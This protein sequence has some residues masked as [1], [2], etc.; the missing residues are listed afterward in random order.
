MA[1]VSSGGKCWFG[2]DSKT[3]E[4][5]VNKAKGKV[6]GT[7][8]ER[9]LNIYSWVRFSGK[10]LTFLLEGAET[11]CCLKVGER[12]KK[13]GQRGK[14]GDGHLDC[15]L[16]KGGEREIYYPMA[17][18]SSGGK[19]WFGVDSKTFEI[20]VNKAKGKV[21]GTVCERGLNIY[22]WVRFSGKGLTFLL[23]GAETYCCLKV[24]ERFKKA[25]AEGKEGRSVVG[26]WQLLARKLRS[27]GFSLSQKGEE[28]SN[29]S[30]RGRGLKGVSVG[31]ED[32]LVE[33]EFSGYA[34]LRNVV[35][36]EIE[37]G[38]IDSNKE[39]ELGG[40][41]GGLSDQPPNLNSLKSWAQSRVKWFKGKCLLLD[42]WNPSVGCLIEDRKSQEVWVRILGLPLHLWG[43]SFFK[44]LGETCDRFVGVDKD[45]VK[46]QNLYPIVVGDTPWI[47]EVQPSW[48][49]RGRG[50]KDEGEVRSRALPRVAE[51]CSGK[52]MAR[53]R[54]LTRCSLQKREKTLFLF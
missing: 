2:V 23:E 12:F 49:C 40:E 19:C 17:V 34:E 52:R 39:E 26:G 25:W 41:M 13:L 42:W 54:W 28:S 46:R 24:G 16:K 5:S 21:F 37:K 20:S 22:S 30:S 53:C 29:S 27:L 47:N 50:G 15:R 4:I 18:V 11:Y 35:W 3:F 9:G 45:T 33:A 10:G 38:V 43:M 6:F 14:E 32:P 8:C 44:N 36:L 48:C 51:V 31:K 7:V 1:V